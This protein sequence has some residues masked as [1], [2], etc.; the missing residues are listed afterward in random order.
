[1]VKAKNPIKPDVENFDVFYDVSI[2]V[3]NKDH[4]ERIQ[5]AIQQKC[6]FNA[7]LLTCAR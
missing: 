5:R 3:S 7:E 6:G 4:A 1:M 2:K